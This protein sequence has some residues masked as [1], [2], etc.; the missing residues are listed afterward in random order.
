MPCDVK[1]G[2]CFNRRFDLAWKREKLENW[3][4]KFLDW[5]H[6]ISKSKDNLKKKKKSSFVTNFTFFEFMSSRLDLWKITKLGVF[7]SPLSIININGKS[8]IFFE[9][10]HFWKYKWKDQW[11]L[12][13][14]FVKRAEFLLKG[15]WIENDAERWL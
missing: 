15:P 5:F 3:D 10:D 6:V 13:K 14:N 8:V 1:G 11:R 4:D 12:K 7:T 9:D 2:P